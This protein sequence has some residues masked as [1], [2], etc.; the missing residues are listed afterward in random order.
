VIFLLLP[1]F[2][3]AVLGSVTSKENLGSVILYMDT[4]KIMLDCENTKCSHSMQ[5]VAI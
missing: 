4:N 5:Y 2:I 3:F 1:E